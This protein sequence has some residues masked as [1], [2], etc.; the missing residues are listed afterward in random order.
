M[1]GVSASAGR[2]G[3]VTA[4]LFLGLSSGRGGG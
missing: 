1:V 4:G 2:P 3:E